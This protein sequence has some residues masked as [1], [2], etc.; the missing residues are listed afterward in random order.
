MISHRPLRALTVVFAIAGA[1][2]AIATPR[3]SALGPNCNYDGWSFNACLSLT[4]STSYFYWDAHVGIDVKL[5]EQY[6][7]E[8]LACGADFRA[9]LWGDDGG[10]GD[11]FI[12][13]LILSPGWPAA[14]PDGIG[15][16]FTARLID[17]ADLD[18]DDGNDEVYARVSFRDCHTGFIR[19]FRTGAFTGG[20][21]RR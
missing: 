1:A 15:A 3:A 13:N 8:V 21:F 6:G 12:R 18:E 9:S 5:P 17:S 16:E 10:S 14:G 11:D 20:D 7:R 2:F 19:N 4:G